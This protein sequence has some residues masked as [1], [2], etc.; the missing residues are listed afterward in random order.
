MMPNQ[1]FDARSE[2][3]I[4]DSTAMPYQVKTSFGDKVVTP[5]GIQSFAVACCVN[6]AT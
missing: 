5:L 2:R 6:R 3:S 1:H 4:D